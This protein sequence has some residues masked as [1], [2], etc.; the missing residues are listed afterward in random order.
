MGDLLF[1][2]VYLRGVGIVLALDTIFLVQMVL[3]RKPGASLFS[4][5]FDPDSLTERGL[6]AKWWSDVAA[7]ISIIWVI[8]ALI[9]GAL[10]PRG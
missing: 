8:V 9:L 3:N 4:A 6:R 10:I 7:A 5:T 2:N 1:H